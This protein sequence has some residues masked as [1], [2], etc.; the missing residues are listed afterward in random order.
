MNFIM[1]QKFEVCLFEV[2]WKVVQHQHQLPSAS[3]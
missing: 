2:S 1:Y 3:Y